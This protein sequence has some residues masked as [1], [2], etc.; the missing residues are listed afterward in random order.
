VTGSGEELL[1]AVADAHSDGNAGWDKAE[2]GCQTMLYSVCVVSFKH[3]SQLVQAKT[4]LNLP[5]LGQKA[6]EE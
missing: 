6:T 1:D 5:E 2:L 4:A 3:H